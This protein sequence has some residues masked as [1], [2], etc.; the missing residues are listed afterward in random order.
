MALSLTP[1]VAAFLVPALAFKGIGRPDRIWNG[2]EVA[3]IGWAAVFRGNVGWLANL[4]YP[5]TL[6]LIVA[7]VWRVA[8]AV[9]AVMLLVG[10]HSPRLIGV[11]LV[12]DEGG[13]THMV[14]THLEK[15]FYLWIAAFVLALLGS[16]LGSIL[17]TD[18]R[19][20]SQPR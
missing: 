4:L 8:A 10:L 9:A 14:L 20:S 1:Y 18:E 19:K 6:I 15:G 7:G 13:V 17:W 3:L 11:T 12:A 16:L 5:P 2:G